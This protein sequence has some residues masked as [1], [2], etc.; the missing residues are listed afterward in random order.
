MNGRPTT[1][2]VRE[3][4]AAHS[5]HDDFACARCVWPGDARLGPMETRET[6]ETREPDREPDGDIRN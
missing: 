1:S 3:M 2:F 6:R 5:F 4:D